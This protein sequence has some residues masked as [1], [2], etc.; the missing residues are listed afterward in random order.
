M[1]SA[2]QVEPP[3]GSGLLFNDET[4]RNRSCIKQIQE[5]NAIKAQYGPINQDPAIDFVSGINPNVRQLR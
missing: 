3:N 1:Y 4:R 2:D 5:W